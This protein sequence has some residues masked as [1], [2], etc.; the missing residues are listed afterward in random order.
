VRGRNIV[1]WVVAIAVLAALVAWAIRPPPVSVETAEVTKG[2]FEQTI[3]DDGKTRV[4]DRYTVSAPLAGQVMRI[5]LKA[6]DRVEQGSVVAVILPAAPSLQDARSVRELEERLGAAQANVLRSAAM[7]ERAKAAYEQARADGARSATLASGGFLSASNLE[8]SELSV[9]MKNRELE[10]ARFERQAHERE[11]AQARAALLHVQ[12]DSKSASRARLG[13]DVHAPISGTVLAVVQ[14][15][16]GPVAIGTGLIEMG[17]IGKLEV[18][19][20]I[21]STEAVGISPGARVHID[22]G[23]DKPR[24]EGRVRRIEPSAFTKVSALGVEEQRV[25]VI[26]DLTSPRAAGRKLGD[27]YRVDASIVVHRADDAVLVPT[28]ALFRDGASFAV[29]VVEGGIARK[30]TIEVP[31]R[32]E[33]HAMA[34]EGLEVGAKVIVFPGDTVRDGLRVE[35]RSAR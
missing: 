11:L 6:G 20:D 2:Q 26:V 15:S 3:E 1:L 12:G 14:E 19:V 29:F 4:R 16:A 8:Q 9:R 34:T 10:A 23:T 18:V 32:N 33:R 13:F 31:R 28:G 21:L 22:A 24:L 35:P 17:D 30:R 25:N 27:G 5:N 7:Q